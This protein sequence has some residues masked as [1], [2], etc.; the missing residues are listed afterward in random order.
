[1]C[2]PSVHNPATSRNEIISHVHGQVQKDI[3]AVR[4]EYYFKPPAPVD[5]FLQALI[6]DK[7]D[8]PVMYMLFNAC[9]I[10]MP[11]AALLYLRPSHLWG[12]VYVI[13]MYLLFLQRFILALHYSEHRGLF[14]KSKA[15]AYLN[16]VAPYV[17][18]PLFGIP[19]GMYRLHHV[20]M[21]HIE[22]N[23]CPWDLSSTEPYQRD[24]ILH[25]IYYWARF[26]FGAWVEL[27]YYAFKRGRYELMTHCLASSITYLSTVYTLFK[28]NP[29]ATTW[30]FIVPF[31]LTSLILMFGNWSQHMFVDPNNPRS[32]FGLAYNVVDTPDNQ[33]SFNDGF[34]IVHHAN[35]RCHWTDMPHKFLET[36]D[37]HIKEDSLTFLGIGF[38][39]V[40]MLV[41]TKQLPTLADRYA[42]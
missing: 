32:S 7:R 34:H 28:F 12:L 9:A 4:N 30:V 35:P 8:A 6:T 19:A 27:P 31:C 36:L 38:L 16:H 17:L 15:G 40:G 25:F 11:S 37:Q 22:N 21:H 41:M 14:A 20:V 39:E 29:V 5:N 18:C 26:S 42:K 2:V 33:K 3:D 24:N 1:M 13:T 23:V 10:M